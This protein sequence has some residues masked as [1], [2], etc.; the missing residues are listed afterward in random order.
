MNWNAIPES[1]LTALVAR[2]VSGVGML[3]AVL[4]SLDA[5]VPVRARSILEWEFPCHYHIT[6]TITERCL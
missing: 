5:E 1:F 4:I 3:F 6:T 2:M